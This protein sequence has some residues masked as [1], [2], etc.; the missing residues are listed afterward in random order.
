[1]L[2]SRA[3]AREFSAW[4]AQKAVFRLH[5]SVSRNIFLFH[6]FLIDEKNEK[7]KILFGLKSLKQ[8]IPVQLHG[9][10]TDYKFMHLFLISGVLG[11][12]SI[13]RKLACCDLVDLLQYSCLQHSLSQF[14][15]CQEDTFAPY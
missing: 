1:M 13:A 12:P 6:C 14:Y 2:P 9:S 15:R 4:R 11:L 7:K 5:P 8:A 3:E 10:W